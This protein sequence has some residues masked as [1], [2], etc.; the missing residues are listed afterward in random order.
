M[1]SVA[2][3]EPNLKDLA[4]QKILKKRSSMII[5]AIL[6]LWMM[7]KT[8]MPHT[9]LREGKARSHQMMRSF[10]KPMEEVLREFQAKAIGLKKKYFSKLHFSNLI[11]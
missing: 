7:M 4:T 10:L 8:Q 6:I 3:K 5:H 2:P 1:T 9:Q 11:P